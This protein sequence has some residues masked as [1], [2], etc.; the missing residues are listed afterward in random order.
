MNATRVPLGSFKGN[1][2]STGDAALGRGADFS[3]MAYF[4]NSGSLKGG[5][6]PVC[7]FFASFARGGLGFFWAST[8]K[9]NCKTNTRNR[10]TRNEECMPQAKARP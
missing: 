5:F 1:C 10:T 8:E 3:K 6:F 7:V 2:V 9:L 4:A